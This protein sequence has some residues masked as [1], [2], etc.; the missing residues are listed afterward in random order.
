MFD[1]RK[2]EQ[3]VEK[4]EG[5][6]RGIA[7]VYIR[8]DDKWGLKL[9]W[10]EDDRD[11]AYN[12]QSQAADC[13][14][15][16]EVG[17]KVDLSIDCQRPYG[18]TTEHVKVLPHNLPSDETYCLINRNRNFKENIRN[19]SDS[20]YDNLNIHFGDLHLFNVGWKNGKYVCIDFGN[21]GVYTDD[22]DYCGSDEYL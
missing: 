16:P 13:G 12:L 18:Y 10:Y 14:L 1:L 4:I 20:L 8:L 15:A 3:I 22:E 11:F 6:P 17:E 2:Q 5:S 19:L 9:F 7:S 21:E